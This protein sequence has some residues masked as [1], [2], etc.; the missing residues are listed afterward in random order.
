M[1]IYHSGETRKHIWLR[2][3][4][5]CNNCN[6]QSPWRSRK[7]IEKWDVDHI[8]PLWEQKGKTF[9]EIDLSYWYEKNLQTLCYK[10]HKD[11]S[12]KE[13]SIRAKINRDKKE[14]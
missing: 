12:K 1:F 14:K 13:A 11:K 7:N 9:D 4:G 5:I 10:C 3:N 6:G 8:R 2:D